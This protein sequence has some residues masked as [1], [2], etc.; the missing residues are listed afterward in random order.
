MAV[1]IVLKTL[2]TKRVSLKDIKLFTESQSP[3]E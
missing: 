3:I 2:E 1:P